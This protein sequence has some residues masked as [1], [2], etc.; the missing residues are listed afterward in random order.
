MQRLLLHASATCSASIGSTSGRRSSG[1]R[2]RAGIDLPNEIES[3]VPSTEWKRQRTGEKWYAGRDDLGRHRPGPG[4]G[5]ADVDGRDDGDGRQ[6]RHARRAAPG[7]GGRRW[8]GAGWQPVP[9]PAAAF[10]PFLMKPETVS[11]R[12]RRPVDGR[13][14]RRHGGARADRGPRRGR[15]D[16]HG[17]GHLE[18]GP[19]AR[20]RGSEQGPARPRLVRVLRAAATTRSSPAWSSPSTPSTATWRR[21]SRATSSKPI[22]RRRTGVP[23]PV[24]D[25]SP[26][27]ATPAPAPAP[28]APLRTA[29]NTGA[30][31]DR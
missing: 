1:W 19:A 24:V 9:P 13:E 6:R 22:S 30:V 2:A 27:P 12:A 5:D 31:P 20:A 14:R 8:H 25:R 16:R 3:I 4:V 10:T 26:A 28:T 18:S 29:A 11:A 7:E 23:L 17:A 21:R 15:Q